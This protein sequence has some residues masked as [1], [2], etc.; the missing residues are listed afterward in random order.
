MWY[1]GD[2]IDKSFMG[3]KMCTF[4]VCWEQQETT[5]QIVQNRHSLLNQI[6]K[7]LYLIYLKKLNECLTLWIENNG[8]K[9]WLSRFERK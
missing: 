7:Y 5:N 3:N 6:R 4:F 9:E 2:K 8:N 1:L